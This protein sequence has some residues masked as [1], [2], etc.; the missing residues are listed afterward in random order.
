MK[1]IRFLMGDDAF[2]EESNVRNFWSLVFSDM[3]K[4]SGKERIGPI[5]T[6]DEGNRLTFD[7]TAFELIGLKP[8]V[9]TSPSMYETIEIAKS[10]PRF[11]W[12]ITDLQYADSEDRDGRGGIHVASSI[13][14]IMPEDSVLAICTSH[15]GREMISELDMLPVDYVAANRNPEEHKMKCEVLAEIL[16]KH[17]NLE[18][19]ENA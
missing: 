12:Y 10:E 15:S 5:K 18:D 3:W 4:F 14:K 16:T 19:S 6:D 8:E 7:N 11:D 13:F 17:Y 9:R 1:P 2:D